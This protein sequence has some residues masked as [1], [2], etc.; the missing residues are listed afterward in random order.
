MEEEMNMFGTE[1]NVKMSADGSPFVIHSRFGH[2]SENH[3]N[4]LPSLDLPVLRSTSL[5][6]KT[7]TRLSS[8][9]KINYT[10]NPFKSFN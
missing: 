5:P 3:M 8:T 2:G 7:S 6:N 4:I 9:S 1:A 10:Q